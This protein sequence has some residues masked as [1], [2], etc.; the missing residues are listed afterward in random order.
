MS[1]LLSAL[2]HSPQRPVVFI[3]GSLNART[4]AFKSTVD[5]LANTH[6]NLVVRYRYNEP[7]KD[8]PREDHRIS[9]GLID[10]ELIECLVPDR[11]G[12]YYFCGPPPFM[13][14]I[15]NQLLTWGI[16][17]AQTHFEFFEPRQQLEKS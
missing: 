14:G 3:H 17:P 5:S 9:F 7:E 4:H 2:E 11:N 1:M 16:P 6:P 10:A 13:A 8:E 12:D 15:Y